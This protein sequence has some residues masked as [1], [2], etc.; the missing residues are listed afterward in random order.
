MAVDA[1]IDEM[2]VAS[3]ASAID[4]IFNIAPALVQPIV[5][6]IGFPVKLGVKTTSQTVQSVHDSLFHR[7]KSVASCL[8]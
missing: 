1:A 6:L 8:G 7:V 5:N 3:V 4:A 2:P